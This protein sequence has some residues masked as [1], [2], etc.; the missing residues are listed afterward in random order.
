VFQTAYLGIIFDVLWHIN[1]S[2]SKIENRRNQL[3]NYFG[4]R[5]RKMKIKPASE[6]S[7]R[8]KAKKNRVG[9]TS[10]LILLVIEG[11]HFEKKLTLLVNKCVFVIEVIVLGKQYS[12]SSTLFKISS[13]TKV[14]CKWQRL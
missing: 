2:T 3:R 9:L 13:P 12:T 1:F 8:V 10:F 5:L 6:S 14:I 11:E 7:G 4:K